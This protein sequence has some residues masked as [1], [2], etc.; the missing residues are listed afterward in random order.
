MFHWLLELSIYNLNFASVNASVNMIN[1]SFAQLFNIKN[2]VKVTLEPQVW[3]RIRNI[4]I[5][6]RRRGV[7]AR[8]KFHESK[9]KQTGINK[10]NLISISRT[11]T[12]A[13]F[14]LKFGAVNAMSLNN[15]SLSIL[16][17]VLD[18]KLDILLIT[19]TW[20]ND[21]KADVLGDLNSSGY[22][23][24]IFPR[25]DRRGGGIGLLFNDYLQINNLSHHNL[26]SF[27]YITCTIRSSQHSCNITLL[28]CYHPPPSK[29][30][31]ASDAVF[32]DQFGILL[33]DIISDAGNLIILGDMN[34]QV[35]KPDEVVPHDY[36]QM[37]EALDLEQLVTFPTHKSHNTL[38][39]VIRKVHQPLQILSITQGDLLSDHNYV[40]GS[41]LSEASL[42]Q[43]KTI[44]YWKIKAI[45]VNSYIL[46]LE[47]IEKKMLPIM[48]LLIL[49]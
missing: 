34:I 49:W 13:S 18:Y 2:L 6:I 17:T 11:N 32:I 1:Y 39:H 33:E 35:N 37:I 41:C 7:R 40:F 28:G 26:T 24:K 47:E 21:E 27:Q 3:N 48:T 16:E 8:R 9:L 12:K 31:I 5:N 43:H 30:N 46:Y 25:E 19:K 29:I 38:D 44:E 14:E 45:G 20:I 42:K 10:Q 15:K 22:T 23:F 36:L 4:G